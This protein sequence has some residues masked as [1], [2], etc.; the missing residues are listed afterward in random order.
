MQHGETLAIVGE[1]GSGKT[2][3]ALA[4]ARLV[5]A[6]KGTVN[7][8]G[9]EFLEL[10]D[11]AL[12]QARAKMQFIFQDPYSSLNPR[13]RA[14][15]IVREPLDNLGTID[16]DQKKEIVDQKS[17]QKQN[18]NPLLLILKTLNLLNPTPILIY[19]EYIFQHSKLNCPLKL[20]L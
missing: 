4:V 5:P 3:A 12:R 18:F 6:Y 19:T 8:D 13:V 9:I 14:E 10:Q 11:E 16:E 20:I 2:T 1:S 17:D 7:L 15:K